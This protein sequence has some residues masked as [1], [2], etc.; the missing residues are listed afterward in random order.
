PRVGRDTDD[1]P[2]EVAVPTDV[3]DRSDRS[4]VHSREGSV[5]DGDTMVAR[6]VVL[7]GEGAAFDDRNA[8]RGEVAGARYVHPGARALRD[9]QVRSGDLER[10][11]RARGSAAQWEADRR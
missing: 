3:E 5:H 4:P 11:A 7:P 10:P 8:H 9:G 6:T 1:L 2:L